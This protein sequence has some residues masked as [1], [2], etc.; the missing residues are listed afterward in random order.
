MLKILV[1]GGFG[2]GKTTTVRAISEI[3]PVST[4]EYLTQASTTTDSLDGVETKGT[5]TVAFDFGRVTF[6]VPMPIELMLF[7][8]PGQER[9]RDL[10]NDLAR[11]A[12][13]AVVL[14]DTRRLDTS[15]DAVT[16]CER[17]KLP[18]VVAVNEFEDAH[19]YPLDDIRRAFALAP[20]IPFVTFDAR[21]PAA[22]VKV[23][24]C[25]VDHALDQI[26]ADHTPL[27]V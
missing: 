2:V 16:F 14:A 10:W 6:D 5:T 13:G 23:L 17:A 15:F 12:V 9:F 8:T 3:E 27:D 4:E 19:R 26:P 20:H 25:L 22:V 24:L 1:A 21:V 18:F 7:G 11:G